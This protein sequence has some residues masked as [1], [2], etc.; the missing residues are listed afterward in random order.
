MS[1]H[2][3]APCPNNL[4]TLLSTYYYD[5]FDLHS[6]KFLSCFVRHLSSLSNPKSHPLPTGPKSPS[7][8]TSLPTEF[9]LVTILSS[10]FPNISTAF[11][12]TYRYE[13]S[14]HRS[15]RTIAKAVRVPYT[16]NQTL[17]EARTQKHPQPASPPQPKTEPK[18]PL[19][20]SINPITPQHTFLP[21]KRAEAQRTDVAGETQYY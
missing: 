17:L 20:K 6:L 4:I 10:P 5:N 16:N 14:D 1:H 11:L 8:I 21:K 13:L 3:S 7:S 15:V 2:H 12:L 9:A 18:N 19:D